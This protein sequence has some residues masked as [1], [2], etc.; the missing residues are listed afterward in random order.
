MGAAINRSRLRI[1]G[2]AAAAT[3]RHAFLRA[4][5]LL[6]LFAV[7]QA[8]L[9]LHETRHELKQLHGDSADSCGVCNIAGHMGGAPRPVAALIP[10]QLDRVDYYTHP[11]VPAPTAAPALS[12]DSRAPPARSL[13]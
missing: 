7:G 11:T 1:S 6:V 2:R 13:A 4:L 5:A 3:T 12:F 10:V 8:A 9:S